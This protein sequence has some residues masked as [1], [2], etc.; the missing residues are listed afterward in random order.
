MSDTPEILVVKA[1]TTQAKA[2]F[3]RCGRRFEWLAKTETGR[4]LYYW[5]PECDRPGKRP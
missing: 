3:C 4:I 5:C 1:R 2:A